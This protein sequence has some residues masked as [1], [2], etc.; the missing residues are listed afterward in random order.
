MNL[1]KVKEMLKTK[2][3]ITIMS[4]VLGATVIGVGSMI[5][6]NEGQ[7]EERK[8][9]VATNKKE[10]SKKNVAVDNKKDKENTELEDKK[11]NEDIKVKDKKE[12]NKE[13]KAVDKLAIKDSKDEVKKT[14]SK[15][16]NNSKSSGNTSVNKPSSGENT[17]SNKPSG[18]SNST[19]KPS[20]GGNTST[21]KPDK[22][23]EPSKPQQPSH[24]HNWVAV[25]ETV[26]HPEQGHWETI[27]IKPAWTEEIPV[28][29]DKEV[30]IC[31]GCN[32]DISH[33]SQSDYA[34]HAKNHMLNG[35]NSGWR[36]DWIQIQV[37][38][39][40]IEH[41]AVTDQKWIVDNAAWTE[42]VTKGYKCS[43]GATK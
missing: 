18:G 31:H 32:Q 34:N 6:Y 40:R 13:D 21:S 41:P 9:V 43:C 16:E 25:T 2:K 38:V 10:D 39:D 4:I 42:T 24:T 14:S 35:E 33:L 20:T 12:D 3:A 26:N 8:V 23:S 22:P 36:S 30:M 5:V 27:V 1:N 19:N 37:G 7:V 29:E 11:E 28:Y 15:E 17:S